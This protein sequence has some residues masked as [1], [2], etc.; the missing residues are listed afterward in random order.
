MMVVPRCP[1]A[2][3]QAAT[4][5]LS[6]GWQHVKRAWSAAAAMAVCGCSPLSEESIRLLTSIALQVQRCVKHQQNIMQQLPAIRGLPA[7]PGMHSPAD[8]GKEERAVK[9]TAAYRGVKCSGST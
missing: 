4:Q 1:H 7:P 6:L 2:S 8:T 9:S 5:C 3:H